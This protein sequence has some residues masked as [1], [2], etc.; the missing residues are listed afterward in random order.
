MIFMQKSHTDK[1]GGHEGLRESVG[2]CFIHSVRLRCKDGVMWRERRKRGG[3][4]Y[5]LWIQHPC[6]LSKLS[7][8]LALLHGRFLWVPISRSLSLSQGQRGQEDGELAWKT[9]AVRRSVVAGVDLI[10]MGF[11]NEATHV[12]SL[13]VNKPVSGSLPLPLSNHTTPL[14]HSYSLALCPLLRCV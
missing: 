3:G 5:H 2:L 9:A 4:A 14:S 1:P 8:F 7:H 10:C 13:N 6:F 12:S 11:L